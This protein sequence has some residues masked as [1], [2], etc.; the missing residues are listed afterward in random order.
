MARPDVVRVDVSGAASKA[1]VLERVYRALGAPSFY[2]PSW[3]ALYDA[4]AQ[5]DLAPRHLVLD[6]WTDLARR[7]PAEAQM[8]GRVLSDAAVEFPDRAVHVERT[9]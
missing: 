8:L 6:G 1:D 5:P 7:L 2:G 3:D 4:L 9:G